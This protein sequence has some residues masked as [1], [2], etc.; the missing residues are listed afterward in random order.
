MIKL[1]KVGSV[2]GE[3][4]TPSDKSI[5]H[6][7]VMFSS[8]AEGVS[9]VYNWLESA[10]TK[11]TLHILKSLGTKVV[12]KGNH[13]KVYGRGYSFLEPSTVLD[14]KNSGTTARLMM[15]VLATQPF[16]STI[17]GDK[18]LRSR[19][20]LRVVEPLRLMGASID[21]REGGNK[22][23]ISVRGGKLKGVSFF[24]K[25]A[26]AQVKSALLLAGLRADG[27]TEVLEPVLSR[28]HTERMLSAFGVRLYQMEGESGHVIKIEGFQNLKATEI[29]C[30]ADPSST[31]FFLALAV[32]TSGSDLLLK[33]VLVNPTRDGF[34]RKLKEMGAHVS[35]ENL[36]EL[37]REPVADVYV[38]YSGRLRAVEVKP[39]EVPSLIDE[40]PV[41]AV[42]MSLAEGVS[43]VRGAEE[44]RV[45]ESDRIKAVVENLR[46]MGVKVEEYK[47]GFEIEGTESL[48]GGFVKTY[49]DHRIAMAFSVAGLT[50]Q[51]ET[52][53][54][55][56]Q[57]VAVSY[58]EFYEDLR[59]LGCS[60]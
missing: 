27:Y 18:S 35:Y 57:C 3:L 22:L 24:N 49:G 9:Y 51:G 20:M 25:K 46:V 60:V 29:F 17:T 13:L 5:S 28:D 4:R 43:K 6:R 32:L 8:L 30:P 48:K 15:G 41:L 31:A 26:S 12:K 11:A 7:A 45:K 58:P 56:P 52:I 19:P 14:A 38:R 34:I 21:G 2:R 16:F 23:P 54:D 10:D 50:A 33:D 47:D 36:R 40:I 55:N 44:L 39:E 53:I 59:K 42:V 37:S 1:T